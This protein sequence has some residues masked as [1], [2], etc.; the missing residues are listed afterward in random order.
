[1]LKDEVNIFIVL[2]SDDVVDL[3]DIFVFELFEEHD[4]AI[5][6]LGVGGV[7]KCIEVLFECFQLFG[8]SI[9]D[10]PNNAICST[11]YFFAGLIKGEHMRLNFVRHFNLLITYFYFI[12][13]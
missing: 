4:F 5:G 8:F 11:S 10:F 2:G 12:Q 1:M 7:G 9:G 13:S 3:D 6:S